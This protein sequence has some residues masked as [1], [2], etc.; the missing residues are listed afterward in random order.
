LSDD[1]IYVVEPKIE[2]SGIPQG[3]FLKRQKIAKVIEELTNNYTWQDFKLGENINFYERIFRVYDCDDFTRQF[4]EY[5]GCPLGN[6]EQAPSDSFNHFMTVKDAKINP[7]D[8]KEYKEYIEVR[9]G[10]GHPNRGLEQYIGNDRKVLSFKL[11]WQ[12]SKYEGGF[13]YFTLNFFLADSA[14]EVKEVRFQNSGKDP[15]PLLLKKQ[16]LAKQPIHTYYPGMSEV[17]EQYYSPED[18]YIG[19]HINMYGRDCVVYDCDDFTKNWYANNIG[20]KLEPISVEEGRKKAVKHEVPPYNG[21]GSV[22]DS[23]GNVYSL[24]PKPP[25]KDMAKLFT[26]DQFVLRYEARMISENRD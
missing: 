13:N 4:Y 5:M 9:L 7:P 18:F 6:P 21:Y 3:V 8:T 25:K 23:L 10:G 12:D 17:P 24:Q 11:L 22:E 15:F 14:V 16:K 19:A 1:T 26:N 2:N 20:I